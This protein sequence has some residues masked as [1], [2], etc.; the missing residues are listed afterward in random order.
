MTLTVSLFKKLSAP[1][2]IYDKYYDGEVQN[3]K[4]HLVGSLALSRCQ[5]RP[6]ERQDT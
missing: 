6:P 3:V 5:K 2:I 1:T 4:I